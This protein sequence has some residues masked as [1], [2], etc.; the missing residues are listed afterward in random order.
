MKKVFLS[1][2]LGF[3][4]L[5]L[6]CK[7]NPVK[8]PFSLVRAAIKLPGDFFPGLENASE[9]D[10]PDQPWY[11]EVQ[12]DEGDEFY[13]IRFEY[14]WVFTSGEQ[15]NIQLIVAETAKQAHD[16]LLD[17][18]KYCSAPMDIVA[19]EDQ[20]CVVGDISFGKGSMFIR[21]NIVIVIRAYG[22]FK[23]KITDIA[24]KIDSLVFK[25]AVSASA[26]SMKPVIKRFEITQN[27]VAFES[28]TELV[29]ALNDPMKGKMYMHWRFAPSRDY[30]GIFYRGGTYYYYARSGQ[31]KIWLT[32]IVLNDSGFYSTSTI[33]IM[34]QG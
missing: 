32:L 7:N 25:S 27:P 3:F 24:R 12:T 2:T 16:Y 8:P 30:G 26:T 4:I 28:E 6:C 5:G 22:E 20:P 33:E 21:D 34:I 13:V 18:R 11:W 29:I 31:P 10:T 1:L 23:D 17:M 19:P 15:V 14:R 9:F